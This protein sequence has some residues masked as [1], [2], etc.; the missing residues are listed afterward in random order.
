MNNYNITI[1]GEVSDSLG[2]VTI[3]YKNVTIR[4]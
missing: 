3:L 4:P 2:A 1:I